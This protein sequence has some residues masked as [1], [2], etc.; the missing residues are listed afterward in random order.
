MKDHKQLLPLK[1]TLRQFS[2]NLDWVLHL[3]LMA[4]I[5]VSGNDL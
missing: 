2:R 4:P 1:Q 5:Q 3:L